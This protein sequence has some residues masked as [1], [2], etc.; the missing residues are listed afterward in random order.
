[1]IEIK[2]CNILGIPV[3]SYNW[4]TLIDHMVDLIKEEGPSLALAVNTHC[5]NM[6]YKNKAHYDAL[7]KA[8]CVYADG[9]SLVWAGK[10]LGEPISTKLTTTDV[11]PLLCER[12]LEPG[13]SHFLLGG[14]KDGLS[15]RAAKA[16]QE[17][18]PGLKIAGSHHG[19]F[20]MDDESIINM[21]NGAQPDVLWVGMGDPRQMSWAGKHIERLNC[22]LLVTCG[23][24]FK[25]VTGEEPRA[26]KSWQEAG[27]EW[28]YRLMNNPKALIFRYSFGIPLFFM[29]VFAQRFF[30]HRKNK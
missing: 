5:A 12:S 15:S 24:M 10:V 6:T 25:F 27:F 19:Y 28:L 30:G 8:E 2:R 3:G 1:M 14:P 18:Y 20:D 29:R 11:W 16:M 13:W 21:I 17:A 7:L 22:K 4:E 9:K 23:G 26:P